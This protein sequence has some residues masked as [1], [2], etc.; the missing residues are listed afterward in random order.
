MDGG[1]F[2]VSRVLNTP[3]SNLRDQYFDSTETSDRLQNELES[4]KIGI[5]YN[6]IHIQILF[7][8]EVT[9]VHFIWYSI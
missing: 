5:D 3:D 2:R 9:D 4:E 8:T 6:E 1:L 7:R